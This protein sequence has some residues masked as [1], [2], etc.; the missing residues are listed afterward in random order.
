[1]I[2]QFQ[3]HGLELTQLLWRKRHEELGAACPVGSDVATGVGL[4]LVEMG[5]CPLRVHEQAHYLGAAVIAAE[6]EQRDT[7]LAQRQR[8]GLGS[9]VRGA[10]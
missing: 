4:A 5:Q 6:T 1:M 3:A 2:L 8:L 9:A 7:V 10:R